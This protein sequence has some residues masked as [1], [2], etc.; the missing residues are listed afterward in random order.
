MSYTVFKNNNKSITAPN[1][2]GEIVLKSSIPRQIRIEV[3]RNEYKFYAIIEK[4]YLT[5]SEIEAINPE[6]CIF[7]AI[8]Y[9]CGEILNPAL[10]DN[11]ENYPILY[12]FVD[13]CLGSTF[14]DYPIASFN[15]MYC[16]NNNIYF[17]K[18]KT[19]LEFEFHSF[20]DV[21]IRLNISPSGLAKQTSFTLTSDDVEI[22]SLFQ[23]NITIDASRVISAGTNTKYIYS[24]SFSFI[25]NRYEQYDENVSG[26]ST[27]DKVLSM[28]QDLSQGKQYPASGLI[29]VG[30]YNNGSSNMSIKV[31]TIRY[32]FSTGSS[33]TVNALFTGKESGLSSSNNIDYINL[34]FT[35]SL[36]EKLIFSDDHTQL[37]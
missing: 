12:K 35:P 31:Y 36:M 2:S 17:E 24:L 21:K 7:T 11:E 10:V 4:K 9:P 34:A 15:G 3:D 25:N 6:E 13:S 23:H 30:N 16:S 20:I 29:Y 8:I 18:N 33:L 26:L 14:S 28:I 19:K 5:L 27:K 37:S 1:E 32:V 22:I